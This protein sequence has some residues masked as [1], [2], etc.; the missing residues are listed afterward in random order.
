M[1]LINSNQWLVS[2]LRAVLQELGLIAL[3]RASVDVKL[4]CM[5]RFVRLFAY[6]SST[7]VLVAFLRELD[8]TQTRIGLFMTL[9]LVGDIAISFLLALIADNVG[10]K[11]VLILGALLMVASGITFALADNYWLLLAAAVLG[12]ISPRSVSGSSYCTH[13]SRLTAPVAEMKS[14]PFEPLRKARSHI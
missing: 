12:V 6:G 11:T 3:Y 10:R 2:K 4:L 1:E 14:A 8:I 13:T 7:L 5:Q 9:T